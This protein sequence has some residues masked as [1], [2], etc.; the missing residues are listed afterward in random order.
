MGPASAVRLAD[1]RYGSQR[2]TATLSRGSN[3]VNIALD[4]KNLSP[5]E[6]ALHVHQVA[7]CEGPNFASAGPHFNPAGKKHGRKNP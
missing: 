7:K 6:H 4:L 5:G 2:S 1:S 3:G